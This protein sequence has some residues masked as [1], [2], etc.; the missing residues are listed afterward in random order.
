MKLT[1]TLRPEQWKQILEFFLYL[2]RMEIQGKIRV[3]DK[4]LGAVEELI[5]QINDNANSLKSRVDG[6]TNN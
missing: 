2:V 4:C 5:D 3:P 1:V 6:H